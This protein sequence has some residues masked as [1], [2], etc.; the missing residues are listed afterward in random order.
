MEKIRIFAETSADLSFDE[1]KQY[2][3]ELFSIP[4]FVDKYIYRDGI[5]LDNYMEA[6]ENGT[7][8]TLEGMKQAIIDMNIFNSVF[9]DCT[10][11]P[12]VAS[13][14]GDLFENGISVVGCSML[15]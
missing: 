13:I 9:V 12:E 11:S 6:L 8:S 3:V 4:L 14:Y 15:G 10:A 1:A 2:G 7:P 5:D